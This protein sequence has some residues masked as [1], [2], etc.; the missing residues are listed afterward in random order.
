MDPVSGALA[1][2]LEQLGERLIS[3]EEAAAQTAREARV[4]ARDDRAYRIRGSGIGERLHE[5]A[6][7][8]LVTDTH[9]RSTTAVVLV[10][11]WEVALA[12]RRG[13]AAL[14]LL[15]G[16]GVGK[17]LAAGWLLAR[18]PGRYHVARDL[19]R[20]ARASWGDEAEAYASARSSRVLVIDEIQTATEP[21]ARHML[22]DIIDARQ[23]RRRPTLILGNLSTAELAA[24]MTA[25]TASRWGTMGHA[26]DLGGGD[27]RE[28]AT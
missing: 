12:E 1:T 18:Y 25:P 15:G 11:R 23:S 16:V 9:I 28:E 19:C 8:M 10:R 2:A 20:F 6:V 17:T 3:D 4:R 24:R 26:T 14:A 21:E 7:G 27:L 13:P 22:A 5:D